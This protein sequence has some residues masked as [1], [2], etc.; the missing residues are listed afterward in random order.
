MREHDKR[1]IILG[2]SGMLGNAV[3][4]LLSQSE[5][6]EVFGTV[7]SMGAISAFSDELKSTIIPGVDIENFDHLLSLLSSCKP[8]VVINCIGLVKQLAASN[9]P[10][11][12][13]PI[14]SIFPHRL[15][16]ICSAIGARLIHMSTDCVFSG[17]KG[18]YVESDF[19]DAYDLYGRSKLIGE[20]DYPHAITLRTS[21]IGHELNGSRSL[22]DWFLSQQGSI[23]GYKNA[24]F[25]GLPTVEIARII[26]DFVIP[27]KELSGVY[28]VSAEPINKF[29]LL[30]LV[31][32]IYGKKIEI[33]EDESFSINRSL[34]ST[35]FRDATGFKPQNWPEMIAR[36]KNF[37]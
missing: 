19:P 18:D 5:G 25:S 14:N 12:A 2:V 6:F 34:D 36:M 10:L 1:I 7:R 21:I 20:V 8:D 30:N 15:A 33:R 11:D 28:H 22:I 3:Y 29:D 32:E 35:R 4:R 31:A 24:I 17:K 37:N 13:L 23:L 27:N 16:N 9:N 26:R